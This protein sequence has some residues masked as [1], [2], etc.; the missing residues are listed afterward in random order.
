MRRSALI[1]AAALGSRVALAG[2]APAAP[3]APNELPTFERIQPRRPPPQISLL[4]GLRGGAVLSGGELVPNASTRLG[5]SV[6]VDIGARFL[7]RFYGG[8]TFD[9]VMFSTQDAPSHAPA[10]VTGLG[11]AVMGGWLSRPE[12]LGLFAQVGLGTH[13]VAIA[14]QQGRADTYGSVE[15]RTMAGLSFRIAS[16]RLVLPRVDLAAGGADGRGH[17]FCTF[18]LSAAYEHELGRHRTDD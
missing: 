7:D 17:A 10:S 13:V 5:G 15:L 8:L 12:R 18:G 9:G 4:I 1:V 14:T 11:F 3:P 16:I 2:D 6:G